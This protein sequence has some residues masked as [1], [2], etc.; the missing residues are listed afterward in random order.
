MGCLSYYASKPLVSAYQAKMDVCRYIS[1][2]MEV[3]RNVVLVFWSLE[4]QVVGQ[5][6]V[7]M[8]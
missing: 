1:G 8:V 2:K 6:I 3:Y 5:Y 4:V 7:L